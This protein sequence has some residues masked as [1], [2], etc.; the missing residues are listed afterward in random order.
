MKKNSAK[1]A[2]AAWGLASLNN[3]MIKSEPSDG[4]MLR[5]IFTAALDGVEEYVEYMDDPD[6]KRYRYLRSVNRHVLQAGRY[7]MIPVNEEALYK[8]ISVQM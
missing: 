3:L 2:E 4:P 6:Q 1:V 7:D 5:H 8:L